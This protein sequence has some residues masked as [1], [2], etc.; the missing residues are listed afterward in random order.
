MKKMM[1]LMALAAALLCASGAGATEVSTW[2]GTIASSYSQKDDTAKTI[3]INSAAE[4]AL[5]AHDVKDDGCDTGTYAGYTITLNVDVDLANI[6]WTPIKLSRNGVQTVFLGNG[7]T[8]Y[9]LNVPNNGKYAGLFAWVYCC[10]V[11]DV[12]VKNATVV[13]TGYVAGIAGHAMC[14]TITGCSVENATIV[15]KCSSSNS[16]YDDGDKA[17]GISG[18]FTAQN[19]GDLEN[20]TVKNC[21]IFAYR[22]LGGLTGYAQHITAKLANKYDN[23]SVI[24]TRVIVNGLSKYD[25]GNRNV[26]SSNAHTDVRANVDKTLSITSHNGGALNGRWDGDGSGETGTA[27]KAYVASAD[28]NNMASSVTVSIIL[29]ES[30][31]DENEMPLQEV[32]VEPEVSV[33]T[34]SSVDTTAVDADGK[35]TTM[36]ESQT[37]AAASIVAD[38]KS[39]VEANTAV[40]AASSTGVENLVTVTA[41]VEGESTTTNKATIVELLQ[42]AAEDAGIAQATA[43]TAITKDSDLSS[44]LKIKLEATQVVIPTATAAETEATPYLNSVSYDVKPIVTVTVTDGTTTTEVTTN[45]PNSEI[46]SPITF[47]LPVTDNTATS[48]RVTHVG[49]PDDEGNTWPTEVFTAAVQ[50]TSGNRYVEISASHFSTFIV[51]TSGTLVSDSGETLELQKVT[52]SLSSANEMALAVPYSD[53]AAN[54]YLVAGFLEDD[55]I[56]VWE[57]T[58]PLKANYDTWTMDGG[59]WSPV[60]KTV[61]STPTAGKA[62][63]QGYGAW[64]SSTATADTKALV[65]AGY[66]PVT[67][68][69]VSVPAGKQAFLMN[70]AGTA[71]DLATAITG[72][73]SGDQLLR[74]GDSQRYQFVGT[75]WASRTNIVLT[76]AGTTITSYGPFQATNSIP[77]AAGRGFWYISHGGAPT[78]NWS[79]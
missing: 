36:T 26:D 13:G 14:P 59:A 38:V 51:E 21:T 19:N 71:V 70:P 23:N 12:N 62:I 41:T 73:S 78:I 11:R 34:S 55:K 65:L 69:T 39:A 33:D 6:A 30:E 2:D 43:K 9:N 15:S 75:S 17:G 63:P 27:D 8:V 47:R 72:A 3:T 64:Y 45:I 56:R 29:D 28:H 4:L 48:A 24:N 37:T 77:L 68:P 7:H 20:C 53:T 58:G 10:T 40:T 67:T 54:A 60:Q 46:T 18:Y 52:K 22:D 1:K 31:L 79:K 74:V 35:T 32:T 25:Y 49:G 16:G 57:P 5:L 50:G 42:K 66:I 76:I 44:E 61:G